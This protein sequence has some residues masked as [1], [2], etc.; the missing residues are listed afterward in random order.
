GATATQR[1]GQGGQA[2][3]APPPGAPAP[4][5]G[6]PPLPAAPPFIAAPV[7]PPGPPPMVPLHAASWTSSKGHSSGT[8]PSQ[9]RR[10]PATGPF[11]PGIDGRPGAARQA[12]ESHIEDQR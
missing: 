4:P 11:I 5:V 8:H 9:A 6:P 3:T 2:S 10:G 7:P 12:S 1:D